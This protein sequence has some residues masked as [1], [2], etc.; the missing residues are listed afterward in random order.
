M[1]HSN[2][3]EKLLNLNSG[4]TNQH[5]PKIIQSRKQHKMAKN[6]WISPD[7]LAF[8]KCKNKLYAKYL[9]NRDPSIFNEYK[10]YRNKITNI[11]RKTK[12]EYLANSFRNASNSS[13][14]WNYMNLLLRKRKR[15]PTLSQTIKVDGQTFTFPE[16]ICDKMSQHF[17]TIGEKLAAESINH[18]QSKNHLNF[19][20]KRN[21]SFIVLQ[22]TD[23]YEIVKIISTLNDHKPWLLGHIDSHN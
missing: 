11:K 23:A 20:G 5:F 14:T 6:P 16:N 8:I 17:A 21:M 22:P 9:K 15:K 13:D 19:L 18:D 4:L 12:Q 3:L 7:I 1:L 2:D 10:K